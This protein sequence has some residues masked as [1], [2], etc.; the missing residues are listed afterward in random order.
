MK[1]SVQQHNIRLEHG[2]IIQLHEQFSE[3]GSQL[4]TFAPC[5]K[6][7]AFYLQSLIRFIKNTI[8]PLMDGER[9]EH[10]TCLI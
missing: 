8:N 2:A 3:T 9:N 10:D 7:I 4:N 5:Q 1:R 6:L